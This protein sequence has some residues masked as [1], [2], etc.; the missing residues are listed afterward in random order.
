LELH[1]IEPQFTALRHFTVDSA[2]H[3]NHREQ[4]S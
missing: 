4:A 1:R 3:Q 2:D